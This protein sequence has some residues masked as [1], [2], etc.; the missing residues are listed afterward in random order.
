MTP[1]RTS[2]LL[3]S[4]H[5]NKAQSTS[6]N[7]T[8]QKNSSSSPT[9]VKKTSHHHH[10]LAANTTVNNVSSS[11]KNCSN[12]SP[13]IVSSEIKG[14]PVAISPRN[15]SLVNHQSF[16]GRSPAGAMLQNGTAAKINH[17]QSHLARPPS[18]KALKFENGKSFLFQMPIKIRSP[19]KGA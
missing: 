1:A 13:K 5:L 2:V 15:S 11:N 17:R 6:S 4:N 16:G 18:A 8:T 14:S 9:S 12:S 10:R 19:Q 7:M 3:D